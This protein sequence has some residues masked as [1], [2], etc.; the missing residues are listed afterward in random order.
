MIIKCDFCGKEFERDERYFKFSV[1]NGYKQYCSS[2]CV[3]QSK[4]KKI[5]CTCANC[6]KEILK[7]PCEIKKSKTGNVFCNKSCACSYNNSHYRTGENNPNWKG[8]QDGSKTYTR[9]ARRFYVKECTICGEKD[10]D[11]IEV[12]HID[13][14]HSNNNLDNPIML[15]PN[16]HMRIH[17]GKLIITDEI[18]QKRKF[19]E[20]INS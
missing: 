2:E 3:K 9:I 19:K 12:H 15:C 11:I 7:T 4:T 20:E 10:E 1:K 14:N 5:K 6:G 13:F 16:C 18:K 8:G 17:R